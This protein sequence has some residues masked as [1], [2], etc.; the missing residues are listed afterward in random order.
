M[1]GPGRVQAR[2]RA[3]EGFSTT[4]GPGQVDQR[5]G[6]GPSDSDGNPARDQ[7]ACMCV[8]SLYLCV[9]VSVC[10]PACGGVVR[11][12]GQKGAELVQTTG[13]T[14]GERDRL[15]VGGGRE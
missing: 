6:W 14:G 11:S 8:C 1:Q 4:L 3:C 7:G 15:G 5:W 13:A 10:V 2:R 12:S 9:T